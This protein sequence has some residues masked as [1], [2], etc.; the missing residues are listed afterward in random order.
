MFEAWEQIGVATRD[1]V[2]EQVFRGKGPVG[3][4]PDF[5]PSRLDSSPVLPSKNENPCEQLLTLPRATKLPRDHVVALDHELRGPDH[6]DRGARDGVILTG[7]M[8]WILVGARISD[9]G[10]RSVVTAHAP[11]LHSSYDPFHGGELCYRP[12]R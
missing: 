1:R 9:Y 2:S 12:V 10:D 11:A 3:P 7:G 5:L 8:E 4:L 6:S